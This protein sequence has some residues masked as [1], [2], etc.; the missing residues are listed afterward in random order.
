MWDTRAVEIRM[1]QELEQA[2]M[3]KMKHVSS[4][5]A[6]LFLQSERHR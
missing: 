1:G 3:A 5:P 6:D 2:P 4:W